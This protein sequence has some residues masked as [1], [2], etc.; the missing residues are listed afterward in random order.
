MILH[1]TILSYFLGRCPLNEA[2]SFHSILFYFRWDIP[3]R[4]WLYSTYNRWL[5]WSPV[6]R[7]KVALYNM[8]N[9]SPGCKLKLFTV[10]FA[11]LH[12][13]GIS[14]QVSFDDVLFSWNGLHS[15]HYQWRFG[16]MVSCIYLLVRKTSTFL[17]AVNT[18]QNIEHKFPSTINKIIKFILHILILH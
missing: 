7:T 5:V 10:P 16:I 18:V 15:L 1:S 8:S 11:G 14:L 13:S 17:S 6:F 9:S 2:T 12:G 3:I 4:W